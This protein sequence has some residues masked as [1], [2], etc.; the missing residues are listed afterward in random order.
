MYRKAALDDCESIYQLI[1]EMEQKTLPYSRFA[2]IFRKQL[3]NEQYYCIVCEKD[4]RVVGVLNLRLEEQLHHAQRIAEILEFV[5][6]ASCRSQGIG[7]EMLSWACRI[8]GDLGCTQIEVA[9][10][11]LRTDT[12]RFYIR[13][14]MHNYHFRFSKSLTGEDAGGNRLGR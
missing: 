5:V 10:N 8:A 6:S 12:H 2:D 14:G 13:E 4:G 9:C 11:Q 1:C 7:K 3:Q